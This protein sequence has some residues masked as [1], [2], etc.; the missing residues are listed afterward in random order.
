MLSRLEHVVSWDEAY[1]IIEELWQ[2][3]GL[4]PFSKE[5]QEFTGMF[6]QQYFRY[7][8]D[9]SELSAEIIC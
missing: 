6:H 9:H 3:S 2:K 8:R 5:S 7:L 1:R 4:T